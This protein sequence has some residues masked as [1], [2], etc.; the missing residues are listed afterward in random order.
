MPRKE[1]KRLHATTAAR[2]S[3]SLAHVCK[4]IDYTRHELD[5]AKE[6]KVNLARIAQ[7]LPGPSL[8]Q[9]MTEVVSH[10]ENDLGLGDGEDSGLATALSVFLQPQLRSVNLSSTFHKV[11]LH[12][13]LRS[14]CST[15]VHSSLSSL[16]YLSHLNLSMCATNDALLT[17]SKNCPNLI[18][19]NVSCSDELNDEGLVHLAPKDSSGCA[20][21]R[22]LNMLKVWQLTPKCV[23]LVTSNLNHLA[24]LAYDRFGEM[25]ESIEHKNRALHLMNF[26]HS[27]S[28][29]K[30]TYEEICAAT[31]ICPNITELKVNTNDE[32][33]PLFSV[34]EK[35]EHVTV[36]LDGELKSG[37]EMWLQ[38]SGPKFRSVDLTVGH[39][40]TWKQ[41]VHLAENCTNLRK[42][43][44]TGQ[45][46]IWDQGAFSEINVRFPQLE[47]LEMN[48]KGIQ[49]IHENMLKWILRSACDSIKSLKIDGPVPF[50]CDTFVETLFKDYPM[51]NLQEFSF[52]KARQGQLTVQ[53]LRLAIKNCPD[54]Q[55]VNLSGFTLEASDIDA[56]RKEIDQSNLNIKFFVDPA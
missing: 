13:Q 28:I 5:V 9:V 3:K 11:R 31:K 24:Y 10:L 54:L 19:L 41:L 12:P 50:I 18:S 22:V 47:E 48:F 37:T 26:D 43:K 8:E 45:N 25:I 33:L 34:M 16:K 23:A 53:T 27:F 55:R 32:S 7:S 38:Y 30:P 35:V 51:K 2:I 49:A 40:I 36:E 42:L 14:N 39:D 21:L 44:F 6:M 52:Q 4:F 15:M 1:P 56:V 20:Q 46:L 17:I 29:Y